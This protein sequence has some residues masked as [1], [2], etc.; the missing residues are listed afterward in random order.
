MKRFK[1]ILFIADREDGLETALERAVALAKTN[2][3]RLTV[4]D[5]AP[6]AGL[7]DHFRRTYGIDFN[8]QLREQRLDSLEA[9]TRPYNDA[10]I[11]VYTTVATGT[12][13]IEVIHAVQRNQ[14]DLVIKVAEHNAGLSAALFGST[15]M[16]LLRKCPCPVWIDG[17]TNTGNY[18]KVLAA[19]DPFDDTSGDLQRLILDLATSL[20]A[21]EQAELE[22]VHAWELPGESILTHS[23]GRL[24]LH[25]VEAMLKDRKEQHQRSLD[26]L[27]L[28][29]GL[30]SGEGNV[31]L[32][33]GRPAQVIT[34][35]AR[36]RE[37]DLIVMG[38][39]GRVSV[40]GLIIGNTAEDVLREMQTA[41]LAVKPSGFVS[42]IVQ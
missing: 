37:A 17:P 21:R 41:V 16:H 39:L 10:G 1:D 19:V 32:R 13:F 22:V 24:P 18:K 33:K 31:H 12:R 11:H 4:M 5:I 8:K 42:P 7:A 36:E 30:S 35:C 9:L 23:R 26:A 3:A 6:D 38:T 29:Y 14:H 27:L 20:A 2:E 25:E 28:A 15:D 34:A 40:P